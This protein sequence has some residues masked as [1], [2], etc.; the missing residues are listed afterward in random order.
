MHILMV[1]P[2]MVPYAKTGGLA[3][4]AGALPPALAAGGDQVSVVIP[5]YRG[6]EKKYAAMSTKIE[7]KFPIRVEDRQVIKRG[8]ILHTR[9]EDQVDVY[10]IKMDE[11]FDREQLYTEGDQDYP[12][13]CARFTFFARAVLEL[14][15]SG[16]V[17]PDVIHSHDWQ[18]AL[19]PIYLRTNEQYC[20]L[21]KIPTVF[22][23]H[24][25]GY[26]GIF[27]HWDM[28]L[29]DVPWRF[30][31]MD[32]LEYF[33]QINLLKGAIVFADAVTT[34]SEGYAREIQTRELGYGLD[35]VLRNRAASLRGI[36]NGID[37]RVW[38]PAVDD[39]IAAKFSPA[40]LAGKAV[41]KAALQQELGLPARPDAPLVASI[42][43]LVDAKGFDLIAAIMDQMMERDLQ[44]AL[45]GTGQKKYH[46]IFTAIAKK[47]PERAAVKIAYDDGLAHRIEAGADMFL[48]PSRYEPCGL[49]QLISKKYGT[50]PVV[51]ATGGLN[52]TI[53]AY[54][55]VNGAGNG[56]KFSDYDAAALWS[57]LREAL[58]LHGQPEHWRTV[59][60]NAMNEDHSWDASASEY[61][62]LYQEL[63]AAK[64]Q[65]NE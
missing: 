59:V 8:E 42:S 56:F 35:G 55:K 34:V 16:K 31:A 64:G 20:E 41:C 44:F 39:Q 2:E 9:L 60:R 48:M 62:A 32:A 46:E 19:V 43:R 52:D 45:L 28:K 51:R 37:Y 29:I 25:L 15:R 30:F 3:D 36:V 54:D 6:I 63:V 24:N 18:A 12:D 47:F 4:V 14:I 13:N 53:T 11:Y 58:D 33:G 50:V 1:A 49:N 21:A 23:I 57:C 61:R 7:L 26:Q 5:C 27:W 40:D 10:L 38:S 17:T 65:G 22:T